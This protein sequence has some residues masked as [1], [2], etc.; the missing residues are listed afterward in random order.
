M[1]KTEEVAQLEKS[2]SAARVTQGSA[3]DDRQTVTHDR[4]ENLNCIW[5]S[6]LRLEHFAP[7]VYGKGSTDAEL[8]RLDRKKAATK[9]LPAEKPPAMSKS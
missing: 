3:K 9:V 5:E 1:T 8:F 4:I 7:A 2:I 6:L